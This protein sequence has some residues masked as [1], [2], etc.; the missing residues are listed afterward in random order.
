M[1]KPIRRRHR[2]TRLLLFDNSSVLVDDGIQELI[3]V[4]NV[5][6]IQTLN[7]C[8]NDLGSG[9]VQFRGRLAKPFTQSILRQWLNAKSNRPLGE[10][11]FANPVNRKWPDSILMRWNPDDFDRL[12]RYAR[13]AANE[14]HR[15]GR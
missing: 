3:S 12:V 1:R 8:R 9:Y 2:Q 14:I 10:I 11:A 13:A 5:P 6:G 4:M 15:A 7:S